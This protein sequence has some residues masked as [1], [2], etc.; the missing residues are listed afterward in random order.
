MNYLADRFPRR[1][2]SGE[3]RHA[4]VTDRHTAVDYARILKDLSD[5]RFPNAKRIRLVRD[6]LNTHCKASLYEAFSPA[7]A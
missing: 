3:R 1:H 4:T 2:A 5:V 6:N 7:E